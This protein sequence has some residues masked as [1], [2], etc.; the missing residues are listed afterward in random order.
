MNLREVEALQRFAAH[1]TCDAPNPSLYTFTGLLEFPDGQSYSVGPQQILLRDSTLQNT[2][3]V[4]GAVIYTGHDTKVLQNATPP[5]S[6]RS[7]IDRTLDKVIWVMIVVLFAMS[8]VTGL[9]FGILT[10]EYGPDMFYLQPGVSD[11]YY[12]PNKAAVAGILSFVT[13]LVLYGYLVPIALYVTL[14]IVRVLQAAFIMPDIHMYDEETGRPAKV[15]STGLNEELGQVDTILSDKTGT[16]TRNQMDFFRCTIAGVSYGTGTT[17]VE[18]AAKQL[19]LNG[20]GRASP[21]MTPDFR[22]SSI[23]SQTNEEPSSDPL[24]RHSRHEDDSSGIFAEDKSDSIEL[25]HLAHTENKKVKGFNFYDPR[26]LGGNWV[27]EEHA[28]M[29]RFFFQIL[30]LCHTAIPEGNADEVATTD[31]IT[32]RAESPDEAALVVAAKEF[33]FCFYKRTSTSVHVKEGGPLQEI[34][35][36]KY[37]LLNILEFSS[38]RK[39]MSVIVR[40][41][42]GKLLLLSKGAD[43]V[44]LQRLNPADKGYADETL[45]HLQEFGEVGLRTLL[46]AY[47]ELDEGEYQQWNKLHIAARAVVGR[48]REARIEEVEDEIEQ[49]LIVIGGTGVEDKL[50]VGVPETIDRLARAGIKIWVLTGDKVETAINIGYACR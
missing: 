42:Q 4:F 47:R 17:E 12:N 36:R 1:L 35:D 22:G 45:R 26:L 7:R 2:G 23:F 32:Y 41:P 16:L 28:D 10:R 29:I 50:Q 38:A 11:P 9:A 6:K 27:N 33:G 14:E 39:R 13:S 34:H 8:L 49:R 31:S 24:N 21:V 46:V 25:H 30:A 19:G 5:P 15:K 20:G 37:E 18:R 43:S 40:F 3:H 48:E 44:M